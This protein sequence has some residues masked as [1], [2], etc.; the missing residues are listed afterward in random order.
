MDIKVLNLENFDINDYCEEIPK[1]VNIY[2]TN[3]NVLYS[4]PYLSKNNQDYSYRLTFENDDV[5]L[6]EVKSV[7]L[8]DTVFVTN[9]TKTDKNTFNKFV[10]SNTDIRD[11]KTQLFYGFVDLN[12]TN[13]LKKIEENKII[14]LN[15][16]YK[17]FLNMN[18]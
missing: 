7:D 3:I 17:S 4:Y 13:N 15:E 9:V 16:L 5:I 10:E 8:D 6:D 1:D 2:D 14:V 18:I 12:I 11:G